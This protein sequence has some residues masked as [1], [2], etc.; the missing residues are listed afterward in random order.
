MNNAK[1][2]A[3]LA[4][5]SVLEKIDYEGSME[6]PWN[7]NPY[8]K[9]GIPEILDTLREKDIEV[10]V[11]MTESGVYVKLKAYDMLEVSMSKKPKYMDA[12]CE[13]ICDAV[14]KLL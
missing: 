8:W 6:Y 12:F 1:D 9:Y 3:L 11:T 2:I 10:K 13:A 14:L 5:W 7:W 4:E